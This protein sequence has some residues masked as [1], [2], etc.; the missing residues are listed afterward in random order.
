MKV[1]IGEEVIVEE[2]GGVDVYMRISGVVDH[3]VEDDEYVLEL[4]CDI[5]VY[6]NLV[7]Y[8]FFDV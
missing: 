4:V 6:F 3:L 8:V 7:K 5:V 1:V 2:L